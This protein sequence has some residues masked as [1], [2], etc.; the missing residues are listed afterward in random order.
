MVKDQSKK[1]AIFAIQNSLY[2]HSVSLSD[3]IDSIHNCDSAFRDSNTIVAKYS[4]WIAHVM[5][6]H[7]QMF[8]NGGCYK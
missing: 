7:A 6:T 1:S 2:D 8:G 4:I 3:S 5:D